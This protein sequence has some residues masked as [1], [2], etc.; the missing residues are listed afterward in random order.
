MAKTAPKSAKKIGRAMP[1]QPNV[2]SSI[3]VKSQ[4][5]TWPAVAP[6]VVQN[7]TNK[8]WGKR[9]CKVRS[10]LFS[11]S[12]SIS[13]CK[14]LITV[15]LG[16]MMKLVEFPDW[17]IRHMAYSCQAAG[18]QHHDVSVVLIAGVFSLGWLVE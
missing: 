15:S 3:V 18:G 12:A 6:T 17:A 2:L 13:A 5:I 8:T 11:S 9:P 10:V 14:L 1:V 7:R 4:A 16:C